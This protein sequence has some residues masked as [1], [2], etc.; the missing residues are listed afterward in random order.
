MPGLGMRKFRKPESPPAEFEKEGMREYR[1]V[2]PEVREGRER[3]GRVFQ[4]RSHRHTSE[5]RFGIRLMMHVSWAEVGGNPSSSG[6][7]I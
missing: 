5:D 4:F 1:H 3:D 2:I 7:W 6:L